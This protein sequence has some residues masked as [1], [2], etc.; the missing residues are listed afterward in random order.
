MDGLSFVLK[1]FVLLPIKIVLHCFAV[2]L[3]PIYIRSSIFEV[4]IPDSS[5]DRII[6]SK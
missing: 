6:Q 2:E 4:I 5:R 1:D 3:G